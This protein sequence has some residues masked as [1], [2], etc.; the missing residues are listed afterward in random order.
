MA[1][2]LNQQNHGFKPPSG[3][4]R[5]CRLSSLDQD[6]QLNKNSDTSSS[7]I[8]LKSP[9]FPKKS[10]STPCLLNCLKKSKS[11]GTIP[12]VKSNPN[13]NTWLKL[14]KKVS[15]CVK[16]IG[17]NKTAGIN[18][19]VAE[20]AVTI[21]LGPDPIRGKGD[22]S[23]L[24]YLVNRENKKFA[25]IKP[26]DSQAAAREAAAY[27]LDHE[28]FAGVPPTTVIKISHPVLHKTSA[29]TAS[30]QRF[31]PNISDSSEMGPSMFVTEK[32]HRIGILDI[33]LYNI[34]RHTGNMLVKRR[35]NTTNPMKSFDLVPID[36]ELC[37]PEKLD[38]PYFEWLHWPCALI[39]F[40]TFKV[41]Y[42]DSLD[43]FKDAEMLRSELPEITEA[44]IRIMVL[45]TIFLKKSVSAGLCLADIG[46]MMTPVND[47][48]SALE[49]LC[50]RAAG[51][52][53]TE[54]FSDQAFTILDW[55]DCELEMDNRDA[56]KLSKCVSFPTRGYG[57][58]SRKMVTFKMLSEK[59]W[60]RFLEKFEE[61]LPLA[62]EARNSVS[63]EKNPLARSCKF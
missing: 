15:A 32:V 38:V 46:K 27:L 40:S 25:I 58:V 20:I 59:E 2:A 11:C 5:H 37:L 52:V 49:V 55:E 57:S 4:S 6:F 63:L 26:A 35:P 10:L 53:F 8:S 7:R 47:T 24:F 41:N 42:I 60:M 44:S 9:Q 33:R 39:N 16:P 54:K 29:V 28:G 23:N 51:M 62:F 43:P 17:S 50:R 1:L 12:N 18:E 30:V 48:P 3:R 56:A 31:V 34:D 14:P 61:L 45:C 21:T 22:F 19:M 36:H 13:L